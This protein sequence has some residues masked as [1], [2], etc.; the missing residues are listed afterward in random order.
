VPADRHIVAIN[1]GL[2]PLTLLEPVC[3]T[4]STQEV[5]ELFGQEGLVLDTRSSKAFGECHIAGA[6]NIQLSS[7]EFE[8]R[9]GWLLPAE[10]DVVMVAETDGAAQEAIRKLAF[11]GLDQRIR[12]RAEMSAWA[13]AGL[14]TGT[15]AQMKVGELRAALAGGNL[16]VLDVREIS[17]WQGGHVI[18]ALH[19]NF[20]HLPQRFGELRLQRDDRIAVICAT[21]KRSSTACSFLLRKGFTNLLNVQGGMEGWTEAGYPTTT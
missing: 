17:E 1:Q 21:G 20:K 5:Q 11:V 7:S 18:S 6:I 16:Q 13:A 12:G 8:Q 9:V 4:L 19:M 10:G 15:V 3:K 14:P 2:R